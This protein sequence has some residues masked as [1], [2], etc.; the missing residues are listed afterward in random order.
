MV[1]EAPPTATPATVPKPQPQKPK[2]V[3]KESPKKVPVLAAEAPT[4]KKPKPPVV[5]ER[6]PAVQDPNT[7]RKPSRNRRKVS[8]EPLTP[9]QLAWI[10]SQWEAACNDESGLYPA[11]VIFYKKA[12]DEFL[13]I[14][15]NQL[16][17]L[18]FQRLRP[19]GEKLIQEQRDTV[20]KVVDK[21]YELQCRALA[22]DLSKEFGLTPLEIH[23]ILCRFGRGN[24]PP[25]WLATAVAGLKKRQQKKA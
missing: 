1:S 8:S 4:P 16:D 3:V 22:K 20:I 13:E 14:T 10:D 7:P 17:S 19:L 5:K 2:A 18:T 15:Y 21:W 6:P 24:N 12:H 11:T 9:E 23:G 25:Y